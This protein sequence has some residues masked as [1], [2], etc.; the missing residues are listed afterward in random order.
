MKRY[1]VEKNDETG[2]DDGRTHTWSVVE[3][4][5]RTIDRMIVTR[6]IANYDKRE[7]AREEC[8]RLNAEHDKKVTLR[9]ALR[10]PATDDGGFHQ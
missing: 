1:R 4:V 5:G 7:A 3:I 6:E 2:L 9:E 10:N 8:R